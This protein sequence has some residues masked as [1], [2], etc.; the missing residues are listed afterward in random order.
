MSLDGPGR[1]LFNAG[2]DDGKRLR[3]YRLVH[4]AA[5]AVFHKA[6]A[7]G[8]DVNANAGGN[9]GVELEPA[10]EDSRG[11]ANHDAGR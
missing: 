5:D 2:L 3:V 10:C 7:L 11:Q 6:P 9:D 1:R 4:Q 8:E